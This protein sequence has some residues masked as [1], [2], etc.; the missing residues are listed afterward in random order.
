MASM[1]HE[2]DEENEE[3]SKVNEEIKKILREK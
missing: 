1:L 3:L 2:K